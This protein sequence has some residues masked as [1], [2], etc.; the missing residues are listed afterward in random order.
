M[1]MCRT[2]VYSKPQ[3]MDNRTVHEGNIDDVLKARTFRESR[4]LVMGI[5]FTAVILKIINREELKEWLPFKQD[6]T[7]PDLSQKF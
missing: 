3:H 5:L 4:C 6:L 7:F 2:Q 1:H